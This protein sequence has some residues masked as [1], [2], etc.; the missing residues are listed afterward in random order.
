MLAT[1]YWLF[2]IKPGFISSLVVKYLGQIPFNETLALFLLH[3]S[4]PVNDRR[5]Y[6]TLRGRGV[7]NGIRASVLSALDPRVFSKLFLSL[8]V[9][10]Y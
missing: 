1:F 7:T 6:Y 3:L 5:I 9:T 10:L 8:L 2:L 4:C